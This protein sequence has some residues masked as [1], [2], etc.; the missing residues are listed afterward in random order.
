MFRS[1]SLPKFFVMLITCM[2][3]L[4]GLDSSVLAAT[5][6]YTTNPGTPMNNTYESGGATAGPNP[7]TY[8]SFIYTYRDLGRA[9]TSDVSWW[10]DSGVSNSAELSSDWN[11][12]GTG[13][14]LDITRNG[15]GHLH[16]QG[17]VPVQLYH[18]NGTRHLSRV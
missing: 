6:D 15:G 3:L 7:G 1:N 17:V 5:D 4:W 12:L 2:T 13:R 18:T 16:L 10:P 14:E 9:L 11:A 8:G